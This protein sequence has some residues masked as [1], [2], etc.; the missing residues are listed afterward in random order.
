M[1]FQPA[2]FVVGLLAL[3]IVLG[4]ARMMQLYLCVRESRAHVFT[5]FGKV[6]G[7]LDAPGFYFLPSTFGVR[8][9]LVPLFGKVYEVST[10][11]DQDYIRNLQVNTS[12]GTPMGVGIWY[13]TKVTNPEAYLFANSNPRASLA[14]N[15]SNCAVS[16][17]SNLEMETMLE[18]RHPLSKNVRERVLTVSREW[19][20]AVGSVYIRKV[21]FTDR[22]MLN[23]ITAKVVNRLRQV[24]ANI[25]QDGAN[26]VNLIA[27]EAKRKASEQLAIAAALRPQ[28]I[29]ATFAELNASAT[30]VLPPDV[31]LSATV[32]TLLE[33]D[34]LLQSSGSLTCL[35]EDDRVTLMIQ[36]K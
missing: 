28:I 18:D 11:L 10:A 25:R 16:T 34:A 8:V 33:V 36:P 23:E 4:I 13:E 19:G 9:L 22:G 5:L 14:G 29:G 31:T 17:L 26:R 24:T 32:Q 21:A 30:G 7:T 27:A 6:I 15:V 2:L 1:D 35:P 12:E 3:P 20:F